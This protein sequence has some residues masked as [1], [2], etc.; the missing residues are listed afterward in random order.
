VTAPQRRRLEP[1]AEETSGRSGCVVLGAI[2][3]IIV[4]AVFAFYGLPPI[5]RSMYGETRIAVGGTYT[6]DAKEIR[7][8]LIETGGGQVRLTVSVLTNKTWEPKPADFRLEL[9]S[10][11]DRIKA[12]VPEP[13]IPE[14]SFD[15]GLGVGRTLVLVFPLPAGSVGGPR[16]LHLADPP[17]RIALSK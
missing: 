13:N 2:L 9:S 1:A 3:G 7:V 12:A 5:L 14:T 17:V 10:G 16:A 6:G 15:F 4:G 8:E 11:G